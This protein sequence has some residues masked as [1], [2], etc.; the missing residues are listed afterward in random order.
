MSLD[1]LPITSGSTHA[2]FAESFL[3]RPVLHFV[4]VLAYVFLVVCRL[5]RCAGFQALS[6]VSP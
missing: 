5:G 1:L 6:Q 4:P 3:Y 2:V